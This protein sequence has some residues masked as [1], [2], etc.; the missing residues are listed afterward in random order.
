[1][2]MRIAC[3]VLI[4]IALAHCTKSI[5]LEEEESFDLNFHTQHVGSSANHLLSASKFTSLKIEIQY[6]KCFRPD[7]IAVAQLKSFLEEHLNKPDGIT[8]VTSEISSSGD[9]VLTMEE[10]MAIEKSNRKLY[11]SGKEL[12]VYILYTNGYYADDKMLG[13]AYLNTSAVM[14]GRNIKENSNSFKK[15]S[16]THLETRVLQHELG[17]LLGLVN[18]GSP[19]QSSHKDDDHGKHC[20]NPQCLMYYLMDTEVPSFVLKKSVPKL[21][22]ACLEDLKANGGKVRVEGKR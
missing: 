19:L 3:L 15:P 12:A 20:T 10:I 11:S 18:V 9:S 13:Y 14:F 7:R 4:I 22:D 17:H 8:I 6:M 1:M 5:A 2:K 16:R 21:D